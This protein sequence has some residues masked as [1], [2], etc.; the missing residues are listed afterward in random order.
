MPMLESTDTL[1]RY[2]KL[3][4][5]LL[6]LEG[7]AWFSSVASLRNIDPLE[8]ALGDDFYKR[9]WNRLVAVGDDQ[10]A[11]AWISSNRKGNW[12]EGLPEEDV[13]PIH[14]EVYGKC[15]AD[16]LAA[17]RAAWCW[18]ASDVESA[19]MWSVFGHQGVAVMTDRVRLGKALPPNKEFRIENM[20]YVDRRPCADQHIRNLLLDNP[21]L[22]LHPYFL[23]AIE[24]RHEQ[25]VRVVAH[26]PTGARGLMVTQIDPRLLIREVV[27]SPLL[28]PDEA[29]AV[30]KIVR[31]RP[32]AGEFPIRRSN[33]A[34]SEPASGFI[35]AMEEAIHG[36]SDSHI[37]TSSFPT[38]LRNL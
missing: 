5:F 27:I 29:E 10:P 26:C 36:D 38:A 30:E 3:S 24:Y 6:L 32:D 1:W 34:T 11:L 15:V 12:P 16:D 17:L 20:R 21:D 4:T 8:A 23:K 35:R 13:G 9:L 37:D 2:M 7:K 33:L 31:L 28:P 22:I 19:A 25:E 18:F 14:S